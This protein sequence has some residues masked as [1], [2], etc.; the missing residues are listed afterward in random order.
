MR[1]E[2]GFVNLLIQEDCEAI[3]VVLSIGVPRVSKLPE[4]IAHFLLNADFLPAAHGL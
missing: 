1:E 2:D 4:H 3:I